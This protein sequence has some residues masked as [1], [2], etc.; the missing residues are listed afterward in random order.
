MVFL[1]IAILMICIS[2]WIAGVV[3][4][5]RGICLTFQIFEEFNG[6]RAEPQ[7]IGPLAGSWVLRNVLSQHRLLFPNSDK[8]RLMWSC[9]IKGLLL[10]AVCG[11]ILVLSTALGLMRFSN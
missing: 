7:Q 2:I 10:M 4:I 8:P 6:T 1:S 3:M 9:S 5:H 11:G